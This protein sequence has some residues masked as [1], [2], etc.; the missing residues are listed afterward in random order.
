ME[1]LL[2]GVGQEGRRPAERD[3]EVIYGGDRSGTRGIT[4][5]G[6]KLR[7]PTMLTLQNLLTFGGIPA[8]AGIK[9]LRHTPTEGPA[10]AAWKAGWL[11]EYERIHGPDF[12]VPEYFVTFIPVAGDARSA[13]FL[14][15]KR[16]DGR[17]DRQTMPRDPSYPFQ[18]HYT[19]GGIGLNLARIPAFDDL[20]G[21]V[22]V[23]WNYPTRSYDYWLDWNKP[24]Q[25]L[26]LHAPGSFERFQGYARVFL[27]FDELRTII[28]NPG[29]NRDWHAALAAVKGIYLVTNTTDGTAYVGKA[30]G[31]RGFLGR[32]AEYVTSGG[33]GGNV[34]LRERIVASPTYVS[35]L[36]WSI[37]HVLPADSPDAEIDSLE[38]LAKQKLGARIIPLN[39]N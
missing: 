36:R 34:E 32:W 7:G 20:E 21:R 3:V 38:T 4:R 10:D 26:E 31:A 27:T 23:G 19:H 28:N 2:I 12:R 29:N 22:I 16:I 8:G 14:W 11:H 13:R 25:V 18:A 33:H 1:R 5:T 9:L 24:T 15:V 39:R 6:V 17:V 35:G 30:A 37:L